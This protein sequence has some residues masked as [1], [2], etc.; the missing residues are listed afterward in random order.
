MTGSMI[1]LDNFDM[2]LILEKFIELCDFLDYYHIDI[3]YLLSFIFNKNNQ[4]GM[5]T[6]NIKGRTIIE[7]I[8]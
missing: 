6:H 5:Y 3:D 8:I 4:T 1:C 2:P 7:G